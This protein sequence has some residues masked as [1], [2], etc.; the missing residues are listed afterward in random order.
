[1][2]GVSSVCWRLVGGEL[3]SGGRVGLR[4]QEVGNSNS[5]SGELQTEK[6]IKTFGWTVWKVQTAVNCG[7]FSS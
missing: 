1:M 5:I 4:V 3:N 7:I 2:E 6:L